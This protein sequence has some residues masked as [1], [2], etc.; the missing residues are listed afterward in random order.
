MIV[1]QG[2]VTDFSS[3]K[4]RLDWFG[5]QLESPLV[6]TGIGENLIQ[7]AVV[8]AHYTHYILYPSDVFLVS[9]EVC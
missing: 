1:S 3:R 9:D 7:H 2:I 4:H 8:R 5:S 6:D